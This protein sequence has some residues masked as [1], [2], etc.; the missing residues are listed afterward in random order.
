MT[1]REVVIS[2]ILTLICAVVLACHGHAQ[3]QQKASSVISQDTEVETLR[4]YLQ[5]RLRNADWKDYSKLITWPDEP[6]WDCTWVVSKYDLGVP[7]KGKQNVVVPVVYK[8]LG[9]FCYDF[10]FNPDPK[11]VTI[12]YELVKRQSG[13]KVNAP[14]PDYPDIS[15]DVLLK[16]L[17]AS[18]ENLQ[19]S[20]ERR[21]QFSATAR[22]L[23]EA[24]K[25]KAIGVSP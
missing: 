13:W 17:K 23:E 11:M 5:L 19:E 18:A 8:R 9:L 2:L 7:K 16:S 6:S 24:L 20:A 14:I 4:R 15:A 3:S 10:E 1:C 12:N 22:K 25:E 21:A